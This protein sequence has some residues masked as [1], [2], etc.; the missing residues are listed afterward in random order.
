MRCKPDQ[1]GISEQNAGK[2]AKTC[3]LIEKSEETPM[4]R[5]LPHRQKRPEM[6]IHFEWRQEL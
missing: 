6:T 5:Y 3:R 4:R 2:I 1:A